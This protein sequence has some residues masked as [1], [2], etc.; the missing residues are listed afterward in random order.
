MRCQK[1]AMKKLF[2]KEQWREIELEAKFRALAIDPDTGKVICTNDGGTSDYKLID[3]SVVTNRE[4]SGSQLRNQADETALGAFKESNSPTKSK[5]ED[6]A[7]GFTHTQTSVVY[8]TN[9]AGTGDRKA[10]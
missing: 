5:N 10:T 4:N 9:I 2:T 8:Q 1:L 3:T 7:S 6:K